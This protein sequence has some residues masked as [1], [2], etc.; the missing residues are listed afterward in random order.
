MHFPGLVS[1]IQLPK[2]GCDLKEVRQC[3]LCCAHRETQTPKEH[4][5][6]C[7][8]SIDQRL[9]ALSFMGALR[10]RGAFFMLLTPLF[11]HAN[12]HSV[13]TPLRV[14]PGFRLTVGLQWGPK[15]FHRIESKGNDDI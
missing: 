14:W 9:V 15:A 8:V 5:A 12:S 13:L 3:S 11:S 10:V 2:R 6:G 4:R 1:F 7:P